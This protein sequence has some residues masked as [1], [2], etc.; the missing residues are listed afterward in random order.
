MKTTG[1]R[2]LKLDC[3]MEAFNRGRFQEAARAFQ[4]LIAAGDRRPEVRCFLAHSLRG[5]DRCEE[6]NAVLRGLLRGR[7]GYVPARRALALI[8]QDQA[9]TA[10][11]PWAQAESFRRLM[12]AGRCA[13]AVAAAEILLDSRPAPQAQRLFWDP[14]GFSARTPAEERRKQILRLAAGLP[15][16]ARP[17]RDYLEIEFW[18]GEEG[19]ARFNRLAALAPG[20]Y[21]WMLLRAGWSALMLCEFEEALRRLGLY[22]RRS[23]PDWKAYGYLAEALLCLQRRAAATAAMGRA[24]DGAPPQERG[25]AL[26]WA[27]EHDLWLGRYGRAVKRCEAAL[28]L[29]S[30]HA[31]CWKGGALV[32]LGRA[33]EALAALEKCLAGRP[34]DREALV[35]KAEAQRNL[36]RDREA[37]KTLSREGESTWG[38]VN[39]ALARHGIGDRAGLAAD[40][41][42]LPGTLLAYL[43]ARTGIS[44][45]PGLLRKGLDLAKGFRRDDYDQAVWMGTGGA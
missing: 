2:R 9:R 31:L 32:K 17:W 39:M 34:N 19:R 6:A 26:A 5:A 45:R 27:A 40:W 44:D 16:S 14:C 7:P 18:R 43:R 1:D 10:P 11:G 12:A 4:S 21:G 22:L 42:R 33:K 8:A 36:G 37:L 25:Q 20:R 29:G 3:G 13:E 30:E 41:A 24:L 28:D 35:W 23:R 15:R 38:L